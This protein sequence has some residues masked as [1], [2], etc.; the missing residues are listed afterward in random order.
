[1]E[2]TQ[3]YIVPLDMK[4][5]FDHFTSGTP[6]YTQGANI[7]SLK[8]EVCTESCKRVVESA[9]DIKMT[10]LWLGVKKCHY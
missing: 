1:M 3:I 8:Y 7:M 2:I 9:E 5:C 4:G 10:K 6:F